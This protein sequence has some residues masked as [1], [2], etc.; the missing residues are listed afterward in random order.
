M[1][2]I[3]FTGLDQFRWL[4]S[5]TRHSDR[6]GLWQASLC[7]FNVQASAYSVVMATEMI[8]RFNVMIRLDPQK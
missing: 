8:K 6:D 4:P 1:I 3:N 7:W 5:I 2:L